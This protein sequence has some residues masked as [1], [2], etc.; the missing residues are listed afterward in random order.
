MRLQPAM[1]RRAEQAHARRFDPAN[2]MYRR[3]LR[4]DDAVAPRLMT[5]PDRDL[6]IDMEPASR[7]RRAA[8]SNAVGFH[9]CSKMARSAGSNGMTWK[10]CA[11]SRSCCATGIGG[12]LLLSSIRVSVDAGSG[13]LSIYLR[14]RIACDGEASNSR[15]P[16]VPAPT[17]SSRSRQKGS[18]SGPLP[19][20]RCGW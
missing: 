19:T 16:S 7:R 2:T 18:P 15:P 9:S 20:N 11:A 8:G 1:R 14:G 12:H 10:S 5:I 4:P 17:A 3:L 13:R 6:I